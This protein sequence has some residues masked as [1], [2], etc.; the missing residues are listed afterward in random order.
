MFVQTLIGSGP[1]RR[2]RADGLVAVLWPREEMTAAVP[3][4]ATLP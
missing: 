4:I 1:R 2:Q 3:S